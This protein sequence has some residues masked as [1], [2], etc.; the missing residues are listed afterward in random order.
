MNIREFN[1]F[2][3]SMKNIFSMY[4]RKS[5]IEPMLNRARK[6]ERDTTE[7][8]Y[9]RLMKEQ[10]DIMENEREMA[11][12]EERS[13]IRSLEIEIEDMQQRVRRADEIYFRAVKRT[14]K[15]SWL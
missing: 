6:D 4:V 8:K 11:I 13:K 2:L 7:K 14:T 1:K 15:E 9:K 3:I 10:R 5:S 12:R